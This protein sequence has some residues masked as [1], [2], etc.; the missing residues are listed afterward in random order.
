MYKHFV[1]EL[2]NIGFNLGMMKL[3]EHLLLKAYCLAVFPKGS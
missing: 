2:N 3:Y 1:Q